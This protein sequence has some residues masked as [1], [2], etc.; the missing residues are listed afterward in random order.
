MNQKCANFIVRLTEIA[1]SLLAAYNDT[2]DYWKPEEPP[3]TTAYGELGDKIVDDF[4]SFS[5]DIRE[6]VMSLIE[7]GMSSD[8]ELLG[9]AVATGLIE[10]MVGRASRSQGGVQ[11]VLSQFGPLS[12][13]HA[14]AWIGA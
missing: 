5:P 11:R 10:A 12:R 13:S 8:D 2:L 14:E 6:A 1:P 9:I 3:L 7:E 4:D